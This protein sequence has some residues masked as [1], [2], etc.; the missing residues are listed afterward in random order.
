MYIHVEKSENDFSYNSIY[1]IIPYM[2]TISLI[3]CFLSSGEKRKSGHYLLKTHI[4]KKRKKT[5]KLS[6]SDLR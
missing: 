6:I 4:H 2:G 3:R 5:A 1:V